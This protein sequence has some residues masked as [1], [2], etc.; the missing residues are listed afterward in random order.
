MADAPAQLDYA[1]PVSWHHRKGVRWGIVAT[2]VLLG[3]LGSVKFL[4]SAWAH[5]RL[6]HYQGR[7][8]DHVEEG[9]RAV[10][11]GGKVVGKV[12]RDWE[13]FYALFSPPGGRFNATA[14][15]GELRKQDGSKRLVSVDLFAAGNNGHGLMLDS[16]VIE[17]GSPMKRPEVFPERWNSLVSLMKDGVIDRLY[18]GVRDPSDASHFTLVYER[19]GKKGVIDGWLR[20]DDSILFEERR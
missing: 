4:P 6:L 20:S 15:L 3:V 11:D 19:G 16:Q 2:L 13:R 9:G 17:P 1:Q 10:F 18:A 7:C 12:D 14:F 8:L 5:V